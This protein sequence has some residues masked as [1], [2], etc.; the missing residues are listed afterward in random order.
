MIDFYNAFISYRH[1]PLDSKVAED[2]QRSLEHFSIPSSIKKKTGRKKI[3]RIF[4]D[5]DELPITS[6]LTETISNALEKA[7]YLIVICS[8]NTK[9][10]M[11]VKREIQFFLKNHTKNQIL[12]VLADGEPRDVIPDE[13]KNE[14]RMVENE[15]GMKYSVKVPIEPLSCDYRMP[16]KR[17]HKEELPRLAAALIGCSYDELVRRQRQYKMRRMGILFGAILAVVL[18]FGGYML[19]SKMQID[20]NYRQTLANQSRY[21]ANESEA[22]LDNQQRISALQLALAALPSGE[23]DDRPVT[24]EAVRALT[25]ATLAYRSID[26]LAIDSVW[27]YQMYN[28]I[29]DFKV[30]ADGNCL[31]VRDKTDTISA[32]NTETHDQ[33][34]YKD[35]NELRGFSFL[36]DGSLAIWDQDTMTVFNIPDGSERW[37]YKLEDAVFET[38]GAVMLTD[39]SLLIGTSTETILVLSQA[40]G[41]VTASYDLPSIN[42]GHLGS[43]HDYCISP[44]YKRIAFTYVEMSSYKIAVFDMTTGKCNYSAPQEMRISNITWGDNDHIVT[45][46][47]ATDMGTSSS[48]GSNTILRTDHNYVACYDPKSLDQLWQQDMTSVGVMTTSDFIRLPKQNAIC[49]FH[50]NCANI[51]ELNTGRLIHGGTVYDPI[52]DASDRDGDGWPLFITKAG[53]LAQPLY[54]VSADAFSNTKA[55]TGNI[56]KAVVNKGIYVCTQGGTRV[57]FYQSYVCDEEWTE[58]DDGMKFPTA[59]I[60]TYLDDKVFGVLYRDDN[61]KIALYDPT[62]CVFNRVVQRDLDDTYG[63]YEIIGRLDNELFIIGKDL[64]DKILYRVNFEDG[65]TGST[66]LGTCNFFEAPE[67]MASYKDGNVCYVEQVDGTCV[68]SLYNIKEDRKHSVTLDEE[69]DSTLAPIY[70]PNSN[71]IYLATKNGDYLVDVEKET[72]GKIDVPEGFSGALVVAEDKTGTKITAADNTAVIFVDKETLLCTSIQNGGMTPMGIAYH[73][74]KDA[75][76]ELLFIA[77]NNGYL[78]RYD[79]DT[80]EVLGRSSIGVYDRHTFSASIDFDDEKGLIYIHTGDLEDVIETETWVEVICLN[81]CYGHSM[82]A[83]RFITVFY[84]GGK[85]LELGYYRHY[86]LDELIAKAKDMLQG[87]EMSL[88]MRAQYG[89]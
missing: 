88:D 81:N 60:D 89:L 30:S 33:I 69:P 36:S 13:L 59:A 12:T 7:E 31:V 55:L 4:R 10:S 77:Y 87:K 6:D 83:D 18:A 37:K 16:F 17:A 80:M 74:V 1:A 21:L 15:L 47:P 26:G 56:S 14:E 61:I 28:T 65:S 70:L 51:Y 22:L 29:T 38:D 42:I 57:I 58:I 27:D 79:A 2:V 32:W 52:I 63:N 43:Y 76:K 53:D 85:D 11:W 25:D 35:Y 39:D 49:Y 3:E 48:L 73:Q 62:A 86:T 45:V 78:Y 82:E 19:Y 46:T 23:D 66:R 71:T 84:K 34:L 68:V 9:E 20:K 75:K 50:A 44:D 64:K 41:S 72:V 40:D 24:A 67:I 8:P 54:N 5:K